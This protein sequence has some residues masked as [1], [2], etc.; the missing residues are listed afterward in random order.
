MSKNRY[1]RWMYKDNGNIKYVSVNY[2]NLIK[3][4]KL[5][6]HKAYMSKN[7]LPKWMIMQIICKNFG[8]NTMK[9]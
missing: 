7:V 2:R 6:T 4:T 3:L 1:N 8:L 5:F 9:I